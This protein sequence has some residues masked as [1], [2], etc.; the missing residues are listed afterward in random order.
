VLEAERL[1][2]GYA[3][4]PVCGEVSLGIAAGEVLAVAGFNGA[5][6]ST[7]VRTLAAVRNRWRETCVCMGCR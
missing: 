2:V 4:T 1:M 7:V 3:G 6:K 5:G